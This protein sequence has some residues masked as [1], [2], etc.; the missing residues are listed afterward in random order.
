DTIPRSRHTSG[1]PYRTGDL[2]YGRT[3]ILRDLHRI[4]IV[5]LADFQRWILPPLPPTT[6]TAAILSALRAEGVLSTENRWD[7]FK[8]IPSTDSRREEVVF[9]GL[10]TVFEAIITNVKNTTKDHPTVY[11]VNNPT[12]ALQSAGNNSSR[13]D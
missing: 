6:T 10:R 3:A 4:P 5:S 12:V 7:T 13:P 2:A 8:N 11:L 1:V 9:E